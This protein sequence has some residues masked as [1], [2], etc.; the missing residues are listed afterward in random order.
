MSREERCRHW[1]CRAI[2]TLALPGHFNY[3]Q[4]F[5]GDCVGDVLFGSAAGASN[6]FC[7]LAP[8]CCRAAV[9]LAYGWPRARIAL[10]HSK[11]PAR[12]AALSPGRLLATA[13]NRAGV[14]AVSE[15]EMD[16]LGKGVLA[17]Q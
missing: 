10:S 4:W 1:H 5:A 17:R 8:E 15:E 12:L 3:F 16:Q 6:W 11:L 14:S 7:F 13:P 9:F 2:V